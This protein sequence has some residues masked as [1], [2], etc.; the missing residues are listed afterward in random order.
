MTSLILIGS[1]LWLVSCAFAGPFIG[2]TIARMN[3]D[4][5]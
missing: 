5:R 2:Q 3:G 4:D 1:A